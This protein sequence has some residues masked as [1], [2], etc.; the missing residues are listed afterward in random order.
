MQYMKEQ[1]EEGQGVKQTEVEIPR[2]EEN[3]Q[4]LNK[5]Q[6]VELPPPP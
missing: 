4:V 2:R 5:L 6:L 3:L 1:E